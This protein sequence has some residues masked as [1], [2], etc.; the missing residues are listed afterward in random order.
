MGQPLFFE[1]LKRLMFQFGFVLNGDTIN[2]R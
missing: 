2:N 1:I